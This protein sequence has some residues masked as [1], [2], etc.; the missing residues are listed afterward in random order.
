M[1]GSDMF[2]QIFYPVIVMDLILI[3]LIKGTDAV[4]GNEYR[5]LV[6]FRY[7]HQRH[8]QTIW[9]DGP[10][11]VRILHIRIKH[12]PVKSGNA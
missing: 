9:V 7:L 2:F 6:S 5:L 11:P 10:V 3:Q 8:P 1:A 4:F 12:L